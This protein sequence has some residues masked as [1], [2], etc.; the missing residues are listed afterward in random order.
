M[1]LNN[2]PVG[3]ERT[4]LF[5]NFVYN[6]LIAVQPNLCQK[7]NRFFK[8][9]FYLIFITYFSDSFIQAN[10]LFKN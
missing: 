5:I 3:R 2:C 10:F 6:S 1:N 7:M 8:N 9:Y 4:N